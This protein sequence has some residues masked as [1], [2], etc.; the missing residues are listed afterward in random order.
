MAYV[1]KENKDSKAPRLRA[2][3]KQYGLTA[4]VAVRHHST[5]QLNVSKGKID[6]I[7]NHADRVKE[8]D[9]WSSE[10][11]IAYNQNKERKYM[12]VSHH[13]TD[14]FDGNAKEFLDKAFEIMFEGNHD[15]SDIMT[16]Y[17]D[18]GWYCDINI[19]KWDKPYTVTA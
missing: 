4:T 15:N 7:T 3:A 10:K 18:V 17:F 5:L 13:W 1:S 2:L 14:H 12:Q 8:L 9:H 11:E 19:G 16:D 6:F